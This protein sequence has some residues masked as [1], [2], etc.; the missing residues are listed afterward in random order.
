MRLLC[1]LK[2]SYDQLEQ[3]FHPVKYKNDQESYQQYL[4]D[5]DIR[6]NFYNLLSAFGRSLKLILACDVS[7]DQLTQEQIEH[8]KRKMKFYAELRKSVKKRY[9]ET[10]DF[11][12][13]EKEMRQLL[14][15][16]ISADDVMTDNLLIDIFASDFRENIDK[17]MD[18]SQ[19][20]GAN[21]KADMILHAMTKTIRENREKNPAFYDSLSE[22]IEIILEEYK[23]GRLEAQNKL[24]SA[25]KIREDLYNNKVQQDQRYPAG[26]L[27]KGEFAKALYDNVNLPYN[28]AM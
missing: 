17:N 15:T 6:H 21:A 12:E 1:K 24:Q 7:E 27:E 25:Y 18:S 2:T 14:D 5:E 8:Y 16:Y 13:Y 9:Q 22:K 19:F 28:S 11:A 4:A 26:V 23:L 3:H 10:I 20:T